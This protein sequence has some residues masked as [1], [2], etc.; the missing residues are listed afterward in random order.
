[1]KLSNLIDNIKENDIDITGI[2]TNSKDIKPGNLF[3]CIK[4]ANVDRHD[5]IEEAINSGA[6][7]LIVTKDI[8]SSVPTIKVD[9]ADKEL[10]VILKR[11]YG[12]F[13][14]KIKL[15]GIT[16]T[17][18]KTT[19][20]KIIQQLL[21]NDKCGY[22]GTLG[23]DCLEYED[24]TN[25]T[26]PAIEKL[27]EYIDLF[28]KKGMKYAVI[29]ASSEGYFYNRL[30][31]IC[32]DIGC[33]TNITSEHL[34]THKTLENY[35]ECKKQLFINSKLQIINSNDL[36]FD[37]IKSVSN[38]FLTY[39]TN[40]NDSL[41]ILDY[42][43]YPN[44]TELNIKLNSKEYSI[45]SSLLGKFNVD[46][47]SLSLLVMKELGYSIENLLEKINLLII[48]GRMQVINKGQDFYCI[49]DY[50]HTENAVKNVLEF[51]NTLNVNR[52][53]TVIG[54]AGGRDQFKRKQ[55]GKT[56]L[57]LSD[58]AYLTQDDPRYE[59]VEDIINMMLEDT[60]N[61]NYE[62]IVDRKDAIRKAINDAKENDLLLFLGKG[63]D[64]YMAIEDRRDYYD[65]LKEIENSIELKRTNY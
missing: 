13:N 28:I 2:S 20:A 33:L 61:T 36:H 26:T 40:S 41:Q 27:Y 57:E 23:V 21:G 31:G 9:N 37:E 8:S 38:N 55:V 29:E 22:I 45:N 1:M 18:G 43:L 6:S 53:L 11:Y 56:T 32:F 46:N 25:N 24:K 64:K 48:P 50:A 15:I 35:I 14:S 60:N 10:R 42:K 63:V 59:K 5:Y 54:Q 3:V 44:R 30:D 51:A 12:S 62:I 49:L 4:G 52:I 65:E 7:A 17:D 39:G 16:G 58:Y 19:T 47:L 34:N